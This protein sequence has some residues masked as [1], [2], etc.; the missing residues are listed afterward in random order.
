MTAK[1]PSLHGECYHLLDFELGDRKYSVVL[2]NATYTVGRDP[3]N[4]IA[5]DYPSIS[6]QHALLLR[7]SVEESE[8]YVFRIVDGNLKGKKST[9]GVFVNGRQQ[10]SCILKHGD[11]IA[12]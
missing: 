10:T 11:Y 3:S 5:L 9:N 4:S 1:Q 6:R 7:I 8:N 2:D 12:F